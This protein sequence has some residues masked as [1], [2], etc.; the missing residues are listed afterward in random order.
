M[1]MVCFVE[2]HLEK[3]AF[4]EDYLNRGQRS[5]LTRKVAFYVMAGDGR[6]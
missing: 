4:G 3:R 5:G 1:T 6:R 2:Q